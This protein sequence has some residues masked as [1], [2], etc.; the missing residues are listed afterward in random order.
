[1]SANAHSELTCKTAEV[2]T[3]HIPNPKR[4]TA[5]RRNRALRKGLTPEGRDRLRR[6]AIKHQ[7]WQYARGPMT[8]AGKA[9][10]AANGRR[11]QRGPLSVRQLQAELAG[12]NDLLHQLRQCQALVGAGKAEDGFGA[13]LASLSCPVQS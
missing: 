8:A 11:R 4:L 5:G 9:R 12:I 13:T 1:M 6:S 7:P 10:S 3:V 2:P